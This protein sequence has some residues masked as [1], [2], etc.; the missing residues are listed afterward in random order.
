MEIEF[1]D[2]SEKIENSVTKLLNEVIENCNSFRNRNFQKFF[3]AISSQ[4]YPHKREYFL[5][6]QLKLRAHVVNV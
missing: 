2:P 4:R 1:I 5:R 6:Q 3:R